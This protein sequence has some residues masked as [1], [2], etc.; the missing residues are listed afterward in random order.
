MHSSTRSRTAV[1][2]TAMA[3]AVA[4]VSA[5]CMTGLVPSAGAAELETFSACDALLGRLHQVGREHVRETPSAGAEGLDY[6][7]LPEPDVRAYAPPRDAEPAATAA[8]P[9]ATA[10][11]TNVQEAGVDEDDVVEAGPGRLLVLEDSV[12]RYV[13]VSGGKP[14][15]RGSTAFDFSALSLL[16]EGDHVLVIGADTSGA[17]SWVVA[18]AVD[19]SDPDALQSAEAVRI[20]GSLTAARAH[21]GVA[22]IVVDSQPAIGSDTYGRDQRSRLRAGGGRSAVDASTLEDWLPDVEGA[23]APACDRVMVPREYAGLG[24]LTIMS[25]DMS[26]AGVLD[27]TSLLTGGESVYASETALYVATPSGRST[28]LHAFGIAGREAATYL[29]SGDVDGRVEDRWSMSEFGGVLRVVATDTG[30]RRGGVRTETTS[31]HTLRRDGDRLVQAGRIDGIG[32]DEEVKAV[33]FA[34]DTGYVVT[35]KRTD[36]LWVLDLR[37]AEHPEIAGELHVPGFSSYL[38]PLD[39]RTL[40]G[41]G[42]EADPTTGRP[43]G[44]K[45][46]TYDVSDPAHPTETSTWAAGPGTTSPAEEDAHAFLWWQPT[47]TVAVPVHSTGTVV[48]PTADIE[49]P[50]ADIAPMPVAERDRPETVVLRADG[51]ALTATGRL[52]CPARSRHTTTGRSAVVGDLLLN[53]CGGG[54]SVYRL[55]DLT[56]AGSASWS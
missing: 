55:G 21:D 10:S 25:L 44:L 48:E 35:F 8:E 13:D 30:P 2:T 17:T 16:A 43:L 33:R 14:V 15:L 36:P 27:T 41:V 22:R 18:A 31:L 34:G 5:G 1:S 37:D 20:E 28:A 52:T 4:L 7:P 11:G 23:P 29:A 56:P 51:G 12:L 3:A 50:A 45:V 9:E 32:R 53:V 38:H 26:G 24:M 6:L 49:R 47:G 19:V 54:V 42:Q 46:S 40:V 39:D